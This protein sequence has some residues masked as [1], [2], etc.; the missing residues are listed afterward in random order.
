MK[1]ILL[2]VVAIALCVS[3]MSCRKCVRCEYQYEY[4]GQTIVVTDEF[5]G[6][7]SENKDFEE[8][9]EADAKLQGAFESFNCENF[10]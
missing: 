9:M 6:K 4:L 5:C 10:D 7:N 3:F 8:A 1:R 2:V